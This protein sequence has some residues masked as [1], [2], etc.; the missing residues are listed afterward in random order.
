MLIALTA[1]KQS[2]KSTVANYLVDR[3]GL[4]KYSFADALKEELKTNFPET[5]RIICEMY[6]CDTDKLF[7]NKPPML[8]HLLQEYGTGVRRQDNPDYWLNILKRKID[9]K[10]GIVIDDLRFRNEE[11]FIK[12]IGGIIV[13]IERHLINEDKHESEQQINQIN[14]DYVIVNDGNIDYLFH[15]ADEIYNKILSK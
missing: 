13:R 3:Y 14:P 5:I 11:S 8:R 10:D 1:F 2:G 9:G 15:Q 6:D 12:S 4:K 7:I